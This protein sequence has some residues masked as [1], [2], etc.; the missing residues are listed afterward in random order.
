MSEFSESYHIKNISLDDAKALIKKSGQSGYAG[1]LNNDWAV[2]V[3][4][5]AECGSGADETI[6]SNN[7]NI[8]LHYTFAE[9]HCFM[10]EVFNGNEK[11][12]EYASDINEDLQIFS[13]NL[14]PAE[15]IKVLELNITES[16]LIK[17]LTPANMEEYFADP[18][19]NY[20]LMDLLGIPRESYSWISYHYCQLIE[21][22]DP[23]FADRFY[24][25]E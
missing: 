2:L 13:K 14:N 9:D 10:F 23:K 18:Q 8:L 3:P 15:L 1:K 4:Q 24:K 21:K 19:F 20:R 25:V 16:D 7:E 11:I 5:S 12:S 17:L 22:E 6:V